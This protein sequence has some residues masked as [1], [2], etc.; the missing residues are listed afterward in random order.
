MTKLDWAKLLNSKRFSDRYPSKSKPGADSV[1]DPAWLTK[2]RTETERDYDRL[3]YS[4]PVRRLADKTQVFPLDKNDSVRTRLTHSHEVSNLSRSIGTHLVCEGKL[5]SLA[6]DQRRNV[7]VMLAAAGLAHDLGNPPFGHQGEEAIRS[8]VKQ[9][10][11]ELFTCDAEASPEMVADVMSMTNAMRRDFEEF[12]GNAQTLRVLSRLQVVRDD[13]G[14]NMTFGT[15]AALMKYTVGSDA[16][17]KRG[18]ISAAKKSGYFQS[19][20]DRARIIFDETGL[21]PGIRHP[22]AFI[23]EACDDISYSIIDAEDSVKKQLVSFPDL[24]AWLESQESFSQNEVIGWIVRKTKADHVEYR[25][26]KLPVAELNDVSMQKFRTYAIHVMVS[27]VIESFERNYDAIMNGTFEHDLL[28]Q[29]KAAELC[30]ELKKFDSEYGYRSR[31]VLEIELEGFNAIHALLDLMWRGI[32]EREEFSDPASKRRTP[33]SRYVYGRMSE[34]YRRV[35]EGKIPAARCPGPSL[36]IRYRE[37]LLLMDMVS[38]MTDSF[39]LSFHRELERLNV[40]ASK[41]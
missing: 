41:Q 6:D 36:P 10:S 30:A 18:P 38:G 9:K 21:Q 5:K 12:E 27:A 34:N 3:L 15:L 7:P 28:T 20:A 40:G 23:M 2:S 22:L 17:D 14:I 13:L 1:D 31:G 19:E 24:I 33:F 39:A 8:W 29:S 25:N 26:S 37:L 11:K 32:T 16:A 35:F 4:A